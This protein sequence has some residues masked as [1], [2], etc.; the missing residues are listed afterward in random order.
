[1]PQDRLRAHHPTPQLSREDANAIY[2]IPSCSTGSEIPKV[3]SPRKFT[4][5]WLK[6]MAVKAG[7]AKRKPEVW[8]DDYVPPTIEEAEK[9]L[10]KRISKFHIREER[11]LKFGKK[12]ERPAAPPKNEQQP[13]LA[14]EEESLMSMMVK[15]LQPNGVDMVKTPKNSPPERRQLHSTPAQP[16]TVERLWNCLPHIPA[17]LTYVWKL[18][19]V[20]YGLYILSRIVALIEDVVGTW[21]GLVGIWG[22][23]LKWIFWIK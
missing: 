20:T 10:K 9:E 8:D 7:F 11:L 21:R 22:S 17:W 4:R 16:F 3:Q 13:A 15:L 12:N 6:N 23:V 14:E 18:A 2:M 5:K 19:L 1:M